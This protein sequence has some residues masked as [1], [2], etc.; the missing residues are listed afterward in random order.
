P[1]L[2]PRHYFEPVQAKPA[3]VNATAKVTFHKDVERILQAHCQSCHRSGE[4]AP[5][6]LLTY[7]D[8]RP[9]AK[10]IRAAVAQKKMPPWFADPNYGKFSNDWR[11][12]Q[13]QID[14][15]VAWAD[16]GAVEGDPKDSP[17]PLEFADG[18]NIGKPD[19]IIEMPKAFHIAATGKIP[20]QYI[21]V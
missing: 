7:K 2:Q 18:W 12:P 4:A 10:A 20:Y 9:W 3:A 11:L 19:M 17:K 21:A 14:T 8:A 1:T 16:G 13:A 5:M 6:S 15:L